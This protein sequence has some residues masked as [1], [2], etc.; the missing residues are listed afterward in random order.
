LDVT[1][2]SDYLQELNQEL[3]ATLEI[4]KNT[5]RA[6]SAVPTSQVYVSYL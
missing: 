4:L 3:N 6:K 5:V 2:Y 1:E